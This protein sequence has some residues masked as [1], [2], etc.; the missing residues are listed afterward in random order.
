[1]SSMN[2]PLS[3]V[4]PL[5]QYGISEIPV[6]GGILSTLIGLFWPSSS[7]NVWD[8]IN[9]DVK[10]LVDDEID[11]TVWQIL[12]LKISQI[13]EQVSDFNDKLTNKEYD[14][15]NQ[16]LMILVDTL[17]GEEDNFKIS[18]KNY[19]YSF[20]PLFVAVMNLKISLY[21]EALKWQ[22]C[23]GLSSDQVNDI[24]SRLQT[25]VA[26]AKDYLSGITYDFDT[27]NITKYVQCL[28]YY[29]TSVGLFNELWASDYESYVNP[30]SLNNYY[31]PAIAAG[32]FFKLMDVNGYEFGVPMSYQEAINNAIMPGGQYPSG[33]LSFVNVSTDQSEW[34]RTTGL[35]FKCNGSDVVYNMGLC[36]T[37]NNNI[38]LQEQEYIKGITV[39]SQDFVSK[40]SF[41]TTL[42][43]NYTFG[44][45][46]DGDPT[47]SVNL[48]DPFTINSFFVPSDEAGY[49]NSSG[50]QMTGFVA[51][52]VYNN[53]LAYKY[54]SNLFSE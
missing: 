22:E 31:V 1:M 29:K 11:E 15:A 33:E 19:T 21:L 50:H 8:A 23:L 30:L 51:A 10:E 6:V 40:L 24:K 44:Q 18:G 5:L 34:T 20:S 17:I 38:Y 28:L 42:N 43:E 13:Q 35:S 36:I 27:S 46:S 53:E 25:D 9:Q 2:A 26:D 4:G 54:V 12:S 49:L 32:S 48:V 39:Y 41:N 47:C 45:N 7:E 3:F 14:L 37:N 16:E 52:A